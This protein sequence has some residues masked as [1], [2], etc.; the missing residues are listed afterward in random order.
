VSRAALPEGY[1]GVSRAGVEAFAWH[2]AVP[3]LESVLGSA[4]GAERQTTEPASLHAWA[5]ARR[6]SEP[7]ARLSGR[8][9]VHVVAAPAAGPDGRDRWAAR[10]YRRG[11][12]A[13]RLLGDRYLPGGR[14]RPVRE[15][16][17]SSTARARGIRTP[18][19]VAGAVYRA[20]GSY[21]ADLVT[22]LVPGVRSLSSAL[23]GE[24]EQAGR[25]VRGAHG[26]AEAPS[27]ASE[28]L[29]RAGRLVSTLARAGVLHGDL[30]AGNVLVGTDGS[31]AWVVD[32]DRCRLVSPGRPALGA[33]MLRRLERSLRKLGAARD[34][35]LSDAEWAALR[36]GYAEG[37]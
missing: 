8:G 18:A 27:G 26:E 4:R 34:R 14:P 20:R 30:S 24:E 13:L 23:F 28:A 31:D 5:G 3:W 9:L 22:E 32:L 25:V 10:H 17:A 15:L 29:L 37:A 33:T 1:E 16:V 19:V 21:T 6:L 2:A 36:G 11:G 35:R 12:V 7:D